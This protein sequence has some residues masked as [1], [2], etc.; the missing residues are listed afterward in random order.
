M[1]ASVAQASQVYDRHRWLNG[2]VVL[3]VIFLVLFP[4]GGVKVGDTPITWG[5]LLLGLSV[6]P[7]LLFRM[8]SLPLVIRPSA[9]VAFAAAIPFRS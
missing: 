2:L 9:L 3:L 1:K 4:K 8:A 7:A 5:Y 6:P